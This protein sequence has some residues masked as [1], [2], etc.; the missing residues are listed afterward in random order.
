MEKQEDA[1]RG[2]MYIVVFTSSYQQEAASEKRLGPILLVLSASAPAPKKSIC[3]HQN[4]GAT[5]RFVCMLLT[6]GVSFF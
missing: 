2:F 3:T 5:T 1:I 6:S 4:H